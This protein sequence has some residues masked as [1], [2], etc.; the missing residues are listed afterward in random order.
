MDAIQAVTPKSLTDFVG[1][2]IAIKNIQAFIT[3]KFV[4]D[5][6][7]KNILCILGPDG[8]GKSTLCDLL[9]KK[10][11]RQVFEVGKDSLTGCDIKSVLYNFA[12]NMTIESY[13][14]KKEKVV[15]IDDIDILCNID[16]LIISKILA[17]N[18]L[19]KQ[20][21]IK[22]IVTCNINDE[23]KMVDNEKDIEIFKLS[24]P[25]S[26]D[27][28]V[29]VMTCFDEHNID[30]DA[31]KLLQ[32]VQK[33]R[34]NICE[35]VLNLQSTTYEL[36]S[37]AMEAGFKDM[38]NFEITRKILNNK[39]TLNELEYLIKSDLGL[40]PFMLYE[41]LPDELD[42]N[43]KFKKG[44]N[45]TS[46]IDVCI[47]INGSFVEAA[48][49]EEKAYQGLD[50]S[51]LGYANILKMNS[52]HNAL[53][54]VEHK[55]SSKDVK[56]RFSQLL[57]KMSHKNIMAKKV[58]GVSNIANVSSASLINAADMHAQISKST[59][60]VEEEI[61]EK[62]TKKLGSMSIKK[63]KRVTNNKSCI[64]KNNF[65]QEETTIMNTYERYFV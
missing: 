12:N 60:K 16:K 9:F 52:L 21:G 63:P 46:L 10:H 1:N 62:V 45:N 7:E 13:M 53:Q 29:Y 38:N 31:E 34:G 25:Y 4:K 18:K 15:F 48:M 35:T 3:K 47:D 27:S 36:D 39:H 33:C 28:Y 8:C 14:V 23:R 49:F 43:Y 55:A 22:V 59:K 54:K 17:A 2:K 64:S 24:Y 56:Y 65:S 42:T 19:L 6:T 37:K 30:Y 61:V 58:R 11:N 41:N 44:K 32:V 50:W 20:K 40:I 26:K 51:F 57:S 5:N